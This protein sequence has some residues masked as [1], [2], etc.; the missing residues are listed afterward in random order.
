MGKMKFL[1][2]LGIDDSRLWFLS[3]GLFSLFNGGI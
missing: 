2:R 1:I 3:F